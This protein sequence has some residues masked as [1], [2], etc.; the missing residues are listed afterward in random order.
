MSQLGGSERELNDLLAAQRK[1]TKSARRKTNPN[2]L[3][4]RDGKF[5]K[6]PIPLPWLQTALSVGG[7]SGSLAWAL[8]WLAGLEKSSLVALTDQVVLEFGFS[9]KTADRLLKRFESLGL[10]QVDRHRGRCPRVHL[11]DVQPPV[12]SERQSVD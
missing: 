10:V 1:V 12:P 6:G 11:L 8:W 3:R 9:R 7:K 4:V 2:P 5:V